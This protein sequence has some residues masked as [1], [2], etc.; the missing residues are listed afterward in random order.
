MGSILS[1]L[2]PS[3]SSSEARVTKSSDPKYKQGV[4]GGGVQK[5]TP[6]GGQQQQ[7]KFKSHTV[8]GGA[9]AKRKKPKGKVNKDMIGKPGNFQ[10]RFSH[11]RFVDRISMK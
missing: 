6:I 9:A 7:Q 8:G 5:S 11:T 2:W 4:G 3:G 1:Y 10:V